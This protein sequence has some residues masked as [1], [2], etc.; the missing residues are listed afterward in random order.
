MWRGL[1]RDSVTGS[2]EHAA[3][4]RMADR[5]S[6]GLDSVSS[7]STVYIQAENSAVLESMSGQCYWGFSYQATSFFVTI[8]EPKNI[9]AMKTAT[10]TACRAFGILGQRLRPAYGA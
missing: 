5:D 6:L 10:G 9:D 7:A 2:T 8:Q 3:T 4:A 1:G